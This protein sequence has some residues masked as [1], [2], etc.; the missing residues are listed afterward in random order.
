MAGSVAGGG[1]E[2]GRL[3]H[4]RQ[5]CIG[6]QEEATQRLPEEEPASGAAQ[7]AATQAGRCRRRLHAQG[8]DSWSCGWGPE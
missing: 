2:Q 3:A 4:P 5:V 8:L 6:A 7:T 1:L